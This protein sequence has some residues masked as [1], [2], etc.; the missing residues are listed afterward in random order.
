MEDEPLPP[1]QGCEC[2]LLNLRPHQRLGDCLCWERDG[3]VWGSMGQCGNVLE[4]IWRVFGKCLGR[5]SCVWE[6][7]ATVGKCG[8]ASGKRDGK[9]GEKLGEVWG[10]FG[11]VLG[12]CGEVWGRV[13]NVLEMC[14]GGLG[15]C[16][17][18]VSEK[19]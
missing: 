3:N 14:G 13:G 8:D 1:T 15:T 4:R 2:P 9:C 12:M 18:C 11:N 16:W 7:W 6:V 10:R 17:E 19:C 5:L